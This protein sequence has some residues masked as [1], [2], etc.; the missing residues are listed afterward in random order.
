[1]ELYEA[2]PTVF[3]SILS[4][5]SERYAVVLGLR[6]APAER[7]GLHLGFSVYGNSRIEKTQSRSAAF[8]RPNPKGVNHEIAS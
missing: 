4:N 1:M 5:N 3:W 7:T 6:K 8:L 2:Q